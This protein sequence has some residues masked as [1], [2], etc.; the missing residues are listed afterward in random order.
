MK[1]LLLT[2]VCLLAVMA[3]AA[4]GIAIAVILH[5]IL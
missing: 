2:I 5:F 1:R 4:A 3:G